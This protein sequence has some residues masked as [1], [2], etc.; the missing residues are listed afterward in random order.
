MLGGIPLIAYSVRSALEASLISDIAV[1]SDCQD[2]LDV[3]SVAGAHHVIL[4]P[5]ALAQ[6]STPTLPV[7]FHALDV[8]AADGHQYDAVCLLQPTTPFRP[9][10][11]IDVC[12]ERFIHSKA[13]SLISVLPVP[14]EYNPHWTFE[15]GPDGLLKIA[16]GE[17]QI[18][19]RRQELPPAYF[20]DGSI[21]ITSV[22]VLQQ[23]KSLYG[24]SVAYIQSDAS[25]YVNIDT[26]E[27]WQKAENMLC[28]V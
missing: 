16:T 14:H 13:D 15:P 1:S 2:I 17:E 19:P 23:Q 4:R 28:V 7:I 12:V 6:D 3:A 18:I 21:Y 22:S 25:R 26:M 10:G 20:R 5:E 9:S 11:F 24:K 8:L 27:D